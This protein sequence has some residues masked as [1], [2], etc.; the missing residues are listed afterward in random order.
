MLRNKLIDFATMQRLRRFARYWDLIGNSGNFVETT[1]FVWAGGG[2]PFAEFLR[3]SEWLYEREGKHHGIPLPRLMEQVFT[4]LTSE[5]DQPPRAV[6]EALWRDFQR[7][8]RAELPPFLRPHLP[9]TEVATPAARSGK[10]RTTLRQSR[11]RAPA[12]EIGSNNPDAFLQEAAENAEE[13]P[14]GRVTTNEH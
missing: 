2:S 7:G 12:H 6:A 13:N 11:H 10:T 5:R 4:Y 3:L 14:A 9:P 1:P 8:E